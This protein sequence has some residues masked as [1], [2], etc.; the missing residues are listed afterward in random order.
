MT[1]AS[2]IS[3]KAIEI[4]SHH[5]KFLFPNHDFAEVY[6]YSLFPAG[7]LFRPSLCLA[8]GMDK[9]GVGLNE[10]G[11]R[12]SLA[13]ASAAL[14]V[15][16]TYTLMHDDLPCMDND[17]ERRGR[18]SSHIKFNEW[19]AL[20]GGDGLLNAS[21]R[22]VS[23]GE[24]PNTALAVKI[25]AWATGP[26]GL[27]QGQV[28]DLSEEMNLSFEN[29]LKT[30]E[31]K[32]ARLIQLSLILGLLYSSSA[33]WKTAKS[34]WRLGHAIGISFQLIDDLSELSEVNPGEH[35]LAVNPWLT[36]PDQ[37]QAKLV[38]EI[39][40]INKVLEEEGL[41]NTK[42]VLDAYFDKMRNVILEYSEMIL[43]HINESG[44]SSDLSPLM[45]V[46]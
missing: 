37:C 7:K 38:Q 9:S 45:A 31:L 34:L 20:L 19:K 11:V 12:T 29:L 44:K 27:I 35:E 5:A 28:L 21:Y 10:I 6:N 41:R 18:P 3:A 25:F 36:M 15:H 24:H 14:E 2:E 13:S 42:T 16:H 23:H 26:K 1:S 8:V 17:D 30:H 33:D 32:T 40:L 39:N 43:K 22:L 46:L 4:L